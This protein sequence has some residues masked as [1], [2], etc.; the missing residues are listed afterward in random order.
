MNEKVI[1][2]APRV[3]FDVKYVC[4]YESELDRA[5]IINQMGH[6]ISPILGTIDIAFVKVTMEA[7]NKAFKLNLMYPGEEI[8]Y[9]TDYKKNNLVRIVELVDDEL[10]PLW[11]VLTNSKYGINIIT[12]PE[13]SKFIIRTSDIPTFDKIMSE[14]EL[15]PREYDYT[16]LELVQW[17]EETKALKR[18]IEFFA[19]GRRFFESRNMP[20]SRAYLLHGPPGNGKTTTIKALSRFLNAKPESF[21]FSAQMQN[22]DKQFISWFLG[23]S[24]KINR[25]TFYQDEMEDEEEELNEQNTHVPIRLIVLED[26]D[27]L[28]PKGE[29]PKTSVTLQTILQAFDGAVERQ[30]MIV[31]ATANNPEALDQQILARRGRFNKQIFYSLPTKE[32]AFDYIKKLFDGE[33]VASDTI[34]EVCNAFAGHS[35]AFHKE[36]FADA[37][38][39]AIEESLTTITDEHV[40]KALNEIIKNPEIQLQKVSSTKLGF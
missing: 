2:P 4:R 1:Q 39:H 28:F 23:D 26:I 29:Q 30:N 22:P 34:T 14:T 27:K 7:I 25:D 38:A 12:T 6:Y 15:A 10:P 31:V 32:Q 5:L 37:A 17:N 13:P 3:D 9:T 8:I 16:A 19:V 33:E 11:S 18:D 40:K 20:Y 24:A 35:Y 36:I 21:D